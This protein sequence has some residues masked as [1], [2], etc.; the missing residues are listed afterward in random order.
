MKL[1]AGPRG[2]ESRRR[3][4]SGAEVDRPLHRFRRQYEQLSL[5]ERGR[6]IGKSEAAGSSRRVARQLGHSDCVV[7]RCWDQWIREISFTRRPGSG[8]P[9]QTIHREDRHIVRNARV[10]P[11]ASSAA[12]QVQVTPSLGVPGLFEP[13]E[14]AWLKDISDRSAHYVCCP[15][16][17]P[18]DASIWSGD[19]HEETGLLRN[20]IRPSLA[21]N[22][23][24][25]SAVKTIVLV[26]GDCVVNASIQPLLYSDTLLSQ[27]V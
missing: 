9:R 27:L 5:F 21:T 19:A 7:K 26:C 14:G 24:L 20:E 8:R 11:T 22:L 3:L 13:Y 2:F 18:I 23:D 1:T 12:I 15:L 16:R 6:V 25:I 4:G 10:H 17:P